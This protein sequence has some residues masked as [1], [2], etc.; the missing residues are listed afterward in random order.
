MRLFLIPISTRRTLVYAQR[1]N[2]ITHAEPSYADKVSAKAASIWLQWETG[3]SG[4][5]RWI[6]DA[7]NKLFNRIPH[8]EWSLKSIPP[9]SARRRDG[10]VDKQT[11]EVL[12]PPSVIEE[13]NVSPILQRLSTERN[14]IHRTRMIWSMVGMPIVAPF[15]IV[16][17]IPNI[18]F[19]YLLYRAFSHWKALSGAKHLEFLLSRNLLAPTPTASLDSVYI[20]TTLKMEA[21]KKESGKPVNQEFML[22]RKEHAQ[23]IA[24]VTGIPALAMECERAYKQVE[25]QIKEDLKKKKPE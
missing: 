6:T 2:K 14:Q 12:Y 7:G 17:V 8:E 24:S 13:K 19:F 3:K 23:E 4:W 11:I 20:P 10:E 16:P 22:I 18:P 5:Q 21:W 9:L 15:A 25:E 1:L